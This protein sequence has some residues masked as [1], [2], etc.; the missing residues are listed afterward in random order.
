MKPVDGVVHSAMVDTEGLFQAKFG[1]FECRASLQ[2]Q[3]GFWSAFW[4]ESPHVSDP[5]NGKGVTDDTLTNG[6]EVDIFEYLPN[7]PEGYGSALHWN[8]YRALHKNVGHRGPVAPALSEGWHTFGVEWRPDGYTFYCDGRKTWESTAALSR[9]DEFIILSAEVGSWAGDIKTAKL[10]DEVAFDYVRVYQKAP[11]PLHVVGNSLRNDK[12]QTVRLQGVN[13][14]S[15]EW[16]NTGDAQ[17]LQSVQVALQDWNASIIRLPLCQDRWLGKAPG[18]TD[19]GAQYRQIVTGVVSAIAARQ[20]Y[21]LLDLHWSDGGQWGQHIAQHSLPDDNS[22]V[23]W[24]SLAPRFAN[25]PAVLFDLYNEP[26]DVTWDVWQHGGVVT[27]PQKQGAGHDADVP[28]PGNAGA[29]GHRPRDRREKPGG[30]RRPGLGLRPHR[31]RPRPCAERRSRPGHPVR[32]P[33]LPVEERLGHA[34]HRSRR[35]VRGL[36]RRGRL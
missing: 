17:L 11:P 8:G 30:R 23:F 1:Y 35:E 18:Q 15:L 4:L 7:K 6:T 33:H 14:A 12:G 34:R 24:Q 29:S 22:L 3:P 10:P 36:R 25:N 5:E 16:S 19:G 31:H 21:V 27:E 26:R 9:A 32:D 2:K 28:F 20:K 13:I